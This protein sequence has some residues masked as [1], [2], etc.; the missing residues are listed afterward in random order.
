MSQ[1]TAMHE[2]W[3]PSL[4]QEDPLEE[5]MAMY[6]RIHAWEISWTETGGRRLVVYSPWDHKESDRTNPPHESA[7]G[8]SE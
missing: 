7:R 8:W 1:E 5:E 6:F 2:M 3:V 4:H